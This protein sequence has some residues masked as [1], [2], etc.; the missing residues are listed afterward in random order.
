MT[1]ILIILVLSLISC[2]IQ[3]Q[4]LDVRLMNKIH[5]ERNAGLD[6]TMNAISFSSY[7]VSLAVPLAQWVHGFA[8]KDMTS[9]E[10]GLRTATSLVLTTAITYGLKYSIQRDRPSIAH[11]Q[12]TPYEATSEPSFP[13]GQTALA[14]ST[15]TSLSIEYPKWYVIAPCFL[16]A[17]AVGYARVHLGEHY[18][19]DVLGG[20]LVGAASAYI[21]YKGNQWLKRKW[22]KKTEEKF[23]IEQ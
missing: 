16:W 20:A 22:K 1:R 14:F 18:P 9:L 8:R 7:P 6:G 5:L 12:Y 23:L 2:N 13:S 11:P 10:Y 19:S 3:A 4:N 21:S 17:G 15:A